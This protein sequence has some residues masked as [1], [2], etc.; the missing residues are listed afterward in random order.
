VFK[1][2]L[3]A[4]AS[5]IVVFIISLL[6]YK[7]IGADVSY[8]RPS[9]LSEPFWLIVI[10]QFIGAAG[11]EFGWRCFLQPALQTKMKRIYASIVVGMLWGIWHVGIFAYGWLYVLS[12]L[13]FSVSVSVLLGE[14]LYHTNGNNLVIATVTHTLLNLGMLLWF[15]EE[16]GDLTSIATLAISTFLVTI[17][18]V[19]SFYIRS[20]KVAAD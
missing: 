9:T 7:L 15:K 14:W 3:L 6:Y 19:I 4:I 12:F 1:R 2:L 18:T 20:K 8:S 17:V 11:E 10:A 13:L 16:F 5:V